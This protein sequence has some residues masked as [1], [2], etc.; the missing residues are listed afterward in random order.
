MYVYAVANLPRNLYIGAKHI[1]YMRIILPDDV[2]NIIDT[3]TEHG[4]EAYAVGGCVRD[5][6]L[7][8]RPGDWDI[9]TSALPLQVKELFRRTIDTGIK[10]GTVTIMLGN[11]GYEVTTYRIDGEYTDS[12]HPNEVTYTSLLREDLERRDFTIN[13]MAY[14]EQSGIVDCFD[15][16]GDL[17]RKLIRCVGEAT[18]RF[19]EDA[20]RMLRAV[21]FSAQLGFDI[22]PDTAEAIRTL[23]PNIAKISKERIHSEL[24]KILLSK[25]PDYVFTAKELGMTK[26]VMPVIDRI[27]NEAVTK[28]LLGKL[29]DWLP[30]RYAALMF[31]RTPEETEAQLKELKL[32]NDTIKNTVNLVKYHGLKPSTDEIQ[33][34]KDAAAIGAEFFYKVL[35]FEKAYYKA[36]GDSEALGIIAEESKIYDKLKARGD[37]LS[38]GELAVKGADLIAAGVAPGKEMGIALNKCLQ[39]V[40]VDPTLNT[41][42]KLIETILIND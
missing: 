41:K 10:H 23:A 21:R 1:N 7:C 12:R 13:A 27:E 6:I 40:L 24:G 38:I 31:E 22:H 28:R 34:R 42:E 35:D 14:N 4:Y 2:K 29:E 3:L 5:S 25:H 15:G 30:Y 8:R 32:D 19:T 26:Y 37:C 39:A 9:T 17:E 36:T 33:I 20:L 11:C 16:I 18:K